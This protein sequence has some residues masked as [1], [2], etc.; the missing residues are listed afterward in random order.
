MEGIKITTTGGVAARRVGVQG[1]LPRMQT[2]RGK[3]GSILG[4][5]S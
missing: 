1:T 3:R 5:R 4:L 2:R